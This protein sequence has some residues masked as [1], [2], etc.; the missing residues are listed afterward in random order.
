MLCAMSFIRLKPSGEPE[1]AKDGVSH[2]VV[3]TPTDD[4]EASSSEDT[5]DED[6]D[7]VE[8]IE[9][10]P[11]QTAAEKEE[12]ERRQK[13]K[14][15]EDERAARLAK[16]HLFLDHA[17]TY[18]W[19]ELAKILWWDPAMINVTP[20]GRWSALH[21]AAR[22]GEITVVEWLLAKKAD[23]KIKNKDNRT[24]M[25][26]ASSASIANL[27]MNVMDGKWRAPNPPPADPALVG[28]FLPQDEGGNNEGYYWPHKRYPYERTFRGAAAAAAAAAAAKAAP[29]VPAS[30]WQ[31]VGTFSMPPGP[32][33]VAVVPAMPV[34]AASGQPAQAAGTPW[35]QQQLPSAGQPVTLTPST[36]M[37]D[38][39][40]EPPVKDVPVKEPPAKQP[41]VKDPPATK[42]K[43]K[44]KAS[45]TPPGVQHGGS[46]SS[47]GG[48][49]WQQ[50][51]S[52]GGTWNGGWKQSD[53]WTETD[54]WQ[55][56]Q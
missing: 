56:H 55:N 8:L 28:G 22:A 17:K 2:A 15:E 53:P 47:T 7:D 16:E 46:S 26:V 51:S 21:Q 34:A 3:L 41:P 54:P 49:S 35:Q 33:P 24:A 9:D 14:K 43:G 44:G 42:G 20:G 23:P 30:P 31:T 32:P 4:N 11:P 12:E 27:L 38:A 50:T 6:S 52:S 1:P 18:D 48:G 36:G 45:S 37:P 10:E 5:E 13:E 29:P 25:D 19:P 40:S 39:P